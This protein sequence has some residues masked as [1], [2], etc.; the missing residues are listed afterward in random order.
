MMIRR[1]L[2]TDTHR[3]RRRRRRSTRQRRCR[4]LTGCCCCFTCSLVN[5]PMNVDVMTSVDM[6]ESSLKNIG[7]VKNV[8]ASFISLSALANARRSRSRSVKPMLIN[9][10]MFSSIVDIS[11]DVDEETIGHEILS[12]DEAVDD[13]AELLIN[14]FYAYIDTNMCEEKISG[15]ANSRT[16]N[17]NK[18]AMEIYLAT[19]FL[20]FFSV[21]ER[22]G[23]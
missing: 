11:V 15:Q 13:A 23:E 7:S 4:L 18:Q 2:S 3:V 19:K 10:S 6:R 20:G 5:G 16:T 12:M 21:H 17:T 1:D 8:T 22:L 9:F 14:V